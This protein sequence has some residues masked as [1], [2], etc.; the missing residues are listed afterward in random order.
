MD[1]ASIVKSLADSQIR[2]AIHFGQVTAKTA[3]NTRVSVKI[4]GS[5]TAVTDV[6]YLHSYAPTVGD[7][8]VL[9]VNKGDII[10]LGDLA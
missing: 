8:V 5:D 4:S 6:R 2:T 1:F 3:G 9:L 7:I 10:V